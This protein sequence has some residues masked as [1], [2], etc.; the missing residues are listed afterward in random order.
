LIFIKEEKEIPKES[1]RNLKLLLNKF[2]ILIF[3]DIDMAGIVAVIIRVMPESL[4]TNLDELKMQIK[5]D[6]EAEGAQNISFEEEEVGF[7]IKAILAKFAWPEDKNTDIIENIVSE[8]EHVSSMKIEDY[9]R[10][11]G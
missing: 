1:L 9:R 11:F 6:L 3:L 4:E 5:K 8:I 10:A 7:G 2:Y